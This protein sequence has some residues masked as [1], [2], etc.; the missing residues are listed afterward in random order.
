MTSGQMSNKSSVTSGELRRGQE[1]TIHE[2]Y[3]FIKAY[4]STKGQ[5]HD[6]RTK[7][8]K[9]KSSQTFTRRTPTPFGGA[10][11]NEN[12]K[13]SNACIT[14]RAGAYRCPTAKGTKRVVAA[15]STRDAEPR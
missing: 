12:L 7:S 8:K 14:T 3:H 11:G 5:L 9:R 1:A 2:G 15:A 13:S 6:G 10:A 4:K